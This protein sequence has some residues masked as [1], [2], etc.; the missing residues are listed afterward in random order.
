LQLADFLPTGLDLP[1]VLAIVATAFAS[2]LGRGFSGF[3]SALIFMPLASAMIGAKAASPLMLII[4]MIA[5][6]GLVPGAARIANTREVALM[7][8]GSLIGIPLGAW[9]L[10]QADPL[11]VRWL[12]VALIVPLL[13]LMMAGWRYPY[14]PTAPLT[15][16]VG[17]VA[18]FFGGVAQVS[19]P[20]VVMYWMRDAATP[21][22]IR[23]SVILYFAVSDFIILVSYLFGGL[24]TLQI[25]GLTVIVGPVFGVGLW[26]GAHMFGIASE[27]SFRRICYAM[28]GASAL[29]SLPLFDGWLR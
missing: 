6:A 15:A 1:L 17:A 11:T 25:V 21:A 8:V 23:A 2:G 16:I 3:G 29:I 18:G 20:P 9:F 22:M 12:I 14:P 10:L 4:E 26:I 5:A 27:T 28:I 19:G 7:T 13:G 24:F